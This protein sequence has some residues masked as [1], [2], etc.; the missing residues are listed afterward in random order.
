MLRIYDIFFQ[1][2]LRYRSFLGIKKMCVPF[3]ILE[4]KPFTSEKE[5]IGLDF[6]FLMDDTSLTFQAA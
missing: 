6:I 5:E 2:K 1:H 3:T 4:L